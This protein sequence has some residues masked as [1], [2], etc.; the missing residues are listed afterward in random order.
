MTNKARTSPDE[1][2]KGLDNTFTDGDNPVVGSPFTI[3]T[4]ATTIQ[5]DGTQPS[6]ILVQVHGSGA[7]FS[8]MQPT[9]FGG[10]V[11]IYSGV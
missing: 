10:N 6:E 8:I 4:T 11:F 1:N 3:G 7:A 2:G 5:L 9:L